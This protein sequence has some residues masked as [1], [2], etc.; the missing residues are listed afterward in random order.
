MTRGALAIELEV[1]LSQVK[2]D[3][4]FLRDQLQAPLEFDPRRRSF[5]YA[6]NDGAFELPG[7][8]FSAAE[9]AALLT[10]EQL[11]E[12]VQPGLLNRHLQPLRDK[13]RELLRLSGHA[14]ERILE[15]IRIH[16][17]QHRQ[18]HEARFSVIAGALLHGRP[19][20][21]HYHGRSSDRKRERTLHP[22]RLYVYRQN[23][24]LLAW[25]ELAGDLRLFAI[26]RILSA[27][28]IDRALRPAE[29]QALDGFIGPGFG[30][31]GGPILGWAELAFR[32]SA[33]RWVADEQWHPRQRAEWR[34]GRYRLS[35][36]YS[37]LRELTHEVQRFVAEVEVISPP[38]VRHAV[39]AELRNALKGY[40][41]LGNERDGTPGS[42]ST[43]A[44][45]RPAT[46]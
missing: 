16:A 38:E 33:A 43:T 35:L 21:I 34:D 24:Y 18:V 23:S 14:P 15:C 39:T 28:P 45:G 46:P 19:L 40:E 2:R 30:I 26:D 9:L 13:V 41:G 42:M 8:R 5:H 36:P 10:G 11:L 17:S 27:T 37:D 25:C 1:S 44:R 22:Y 3:L 20:A 31:F 12:A 32:P 4:A 29:P 7:L 6:G